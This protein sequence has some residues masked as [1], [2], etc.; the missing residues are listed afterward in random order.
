MERAK[1]TQADKVQRQIRRGLQNVAAELATRN[2]CTKLKFLMRLGDG[3][4]HGKV[5]YYLQQSN[6][7]LYPKNVDQL[8]SCVCADLEQLP[9]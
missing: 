1:L 9:R 2:R 8:L 6:S 4:S 3:K 5:R 7:C